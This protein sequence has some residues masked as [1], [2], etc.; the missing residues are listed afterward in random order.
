MR[1]T[2]TDSDRGDPSCTTRSTAPTSMPSS[3]DAVATTTDSSPDL[4]LCSA[5]KRRWRLKLHPANYYQGCIYAWNGYREG[6]A[7]KDIR[8]KVD[9]GLLE[10]V[11]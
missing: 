9:K 2:N 7:L 6:K 1:C 5:A 11:H 8:F 10:L 3:S 4:S